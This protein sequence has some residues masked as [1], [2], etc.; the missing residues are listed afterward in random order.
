MFNHIGYES[1]QC[2]EKSVLYR[3]RRDLGVIQVEVGWIDPGI[4]ADDPGYH[5]HTAAVVLAFR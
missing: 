1:V 5:W 2:D 3:S 4:A